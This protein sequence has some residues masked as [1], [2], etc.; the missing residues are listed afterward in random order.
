MK[1]FLFT[2]DNLDLARAEAETLTKKGKLEENVLLINT[3]NITNRLAYTRLIGELLFEATK[4]DIQS[5]IKKYNWNK[6]IKTTFAVNVFEKKEESQSLSKLYGGMIYD[7]LKTP[8]VD[9]NN[10]GTKIVIIKTKKKFYVCIQ[11]WEN[12]ANFISRHPKTRPGQKPIT[13]L[14]R[15]ARVCVNLT[16]A[17][18]EIYDPMCG[19][20]GFLV[21]AGLMNLFP[22]GS[23]ISQEM[24][25]LCSLNL[26]HYNL[27][28]YL[29]F[30]QDF[31]ENKNKYDYILTDVPY[32]KNT[33]DITK[34][35]YKQFLA[36]LETVLKKRAVLMFPHF[37]KAETLIKKSKLKIKGKYS[38]YIHKSLTREIFV[39][40]K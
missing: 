1:L 22:I 19:V 5:K 18:K 8:K 9:L 27:N 29:L 38:I 35:F 4:K 28:K 15:I 37:A 12:E 32:G 7:Q 36:K 23:D 10:P 33:K 14:P 40:E 3:K 25:K 34:D 6:I 20:G 16:G 21:E 31:L 24:I 26:K 17:T 13:I 2:K 11:E 39:V 30:K